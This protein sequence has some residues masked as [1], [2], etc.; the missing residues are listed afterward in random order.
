MSI[1]KK[2]ANRDHEENSSVTTKTY[3]R[4]GMPKCLRKNKRRRNRVAKRYEER[5]DFADS[6]ASASN[7]DE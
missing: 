4:H 5:L 6:A 2:Y 3:S 7:T 1:A